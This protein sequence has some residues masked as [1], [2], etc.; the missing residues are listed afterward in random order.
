MY[1]LDTDT[2]IRFLRGEATVLNMIRSLERDEVHTSMPTVYELEVGMEKATT[3][4]R[5]KRYALDKMLDLIAIAPFGHN[6]AKEAARIRSDL[7]KK[8]MPIGSIDYL[9]AGVAR[10]HDCT[11]VTGNSREFKRVKN[12]KLEKW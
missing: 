5:E 3:N 2:C 1:L 7:E 6:E 9:I 10:S 8:G 11:L 12:L 4:V